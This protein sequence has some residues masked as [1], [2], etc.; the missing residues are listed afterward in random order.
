[1]QKCSTMEKG[2]NICQSSQEADGRGPN[3]M[4]G[5]K[6]VRVNTVYLLSLSLTL[7][8]LFTMSDHQTRLGFR[9]ICRFYAASTQK[10]TQPPGLW[11]P[12]LPEMV[13]WWNIH[14][15]T[16]YYTMRNNKRIPLNIMPLS[17]KSGGVCMK[18]C[19]CGWEVARLNLLNFRG[20]CHSCPSHHSF[21]LRQYFHWLRGDF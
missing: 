18:C 6:A 15:K 17:Q 21:I 2:G 19:M 3:M 10:A 20:W 11:Q 13:Q 16:H 4:S 1:M 7:S 14:L 8:S 12:Q 9:V 5:S